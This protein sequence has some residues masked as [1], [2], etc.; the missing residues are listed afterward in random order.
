MTVNKYVR[1]PCTVEA[2]RVTVED[3]DEIARWCNGKVRG[4]SITFPRIRDKSR[5]LD[6]Q[7]RRSYAVLGQV[8]IKTAK[9]FKVMDGPEFDSKFPTIVKEKE[10]EST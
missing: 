1:K 6:S 4:Y 9:G 3:L 2:G 8:I 10:E 7:D 5:P